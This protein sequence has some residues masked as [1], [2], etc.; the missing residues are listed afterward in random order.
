MMYL[1]S[2]T[3]L[4][5][6]TE[7]EHGPNATSTDLPSASSVISPEVEN[8]KKISI[9]ERI[10][11]NK[12]WT[13]SRTQ[14]ESDKAATIYFLALRKKLN[15]KFSDKCTPKN[16]LWLEIA[17]NMNE[18]G[19]FVGEGTEGREKCRQKFVNLHSSYIKYMDKKRSTGEGIY[20]FTSFASI[21]KIIQDGRKS[22]FFFKV[23]FTLF[24]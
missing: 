2:N 16:S 7:I 17:G 3:Y 4:Q 8:N 21:L 13:T 19:F 24:L 23:I 6:L 15:H 20:I 18:A 12:V 11:R 9:G 14:T 5:Q 10:R 22:I 1:H